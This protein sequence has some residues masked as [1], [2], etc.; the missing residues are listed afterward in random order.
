LVV[1]Q[2]KGLRWHAAQV[3]SDM[4]VMSQLSKYTFEIALVIGTGVLA[5][6]QFLTREVSAAVAI[7]AVFLVAASRITP[8][9]LRL[10]QAALNI[11][12]SRGVA[13]STFVL[14]KELSQHVYNLEPV[15]G[16]AERVVAG[17]Q[18][19]YSGFVGEIC[20]KS[21]TL[22]YPGAASPA[23]VDIS[24]TLAQGDSLA[25]VG[26]TGAGK[27]TLA[28]VILGVLHPDSGDVSVSGVEP[29]VAT[30]RWPGV[31]G[32]VPQDIVVIGGTVRENV[33]LGIPS[34]Y[35]DD[36]L[37]WEAL[38]RA[39]LDEVIWERSDGLDSKVGEQ[40]VRLSGG[41][42]Q[43]LGL[44]RA[45]Y[46]RPRLLVLDEAT[47]ALDAETESSIGAALQDLHGSVTLV[48]VAHRLA[49]IRTCTQ[50]AYLERGRLA[51]LGTFDE[52]R[53]LQPNFDKQARLLG[54]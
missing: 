52:V 12:T 13:A 1:N 43:R 53:K 42:R 27:S 22:N 23:L 16:L 44:A 7:I 49:T 4:Q 20:L 17:V 31:A 6:S 28:D 3:Q 48:V 25:L 32:Y 5:L 29:L 19:G 33:A 2:F 54:L 51:A 47:S 30:S 40:G 26:Q 39:Y 11:R 34:E 46:T 35:V 45:L 14:H 50:V 18:S 21:V 41:Q 38:K 9:M 24:L 10:Q 36:R 15:Q 8:S 37:V